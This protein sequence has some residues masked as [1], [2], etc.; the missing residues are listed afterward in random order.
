MKI[1]YM[2]ISTGGNSKS[3]EGQK[4]EKQSFDMQHDALIAAEVAE[5]QIYQDRLS[6]KNTERPGLIACLKALRE[7][8]TLVVWRLDRLGRDLKHLI[9]TIDDLTRRGVAFQCLTGLQVD[10]TSPT[11]RFMLQVFG[12][13]AEFERE[14]IR[15]RVMAGL[16]SAR[17]RGRKGGRKN[18]LTPAKLRT[19][20]AAMTHRDTSVADLCG[21]LKIAVSTLYM[22]VKPTGELTD[23]GAALLSKHR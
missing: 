6:G 2:R 13:L 7:G 8:D 23:K 16:E 15:E 18:V 10:T 21:E 4:R 9:E 20:Q 11:G 5:D 12:G 22:Y 14:L 1:G 19:A 3:E 17:L